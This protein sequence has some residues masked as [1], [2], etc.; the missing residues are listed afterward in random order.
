MFYYF[1]TYQIC[2]SFAMVAISNLIPMWIFTYPEASRRLRN[3]L[4]ASKSMSLFYKRG[5]NIRDYHNQEVTN[6]NGI[7]FQLLKYDYKHIYL[8]RLFF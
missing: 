1:F 8:K 6:F 2:K 4:I 5:K 7:F 3:R